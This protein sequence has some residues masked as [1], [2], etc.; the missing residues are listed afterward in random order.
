MIC[1]LVRVEVRQTIVPCSSR[2]LD[3]GIAGLRKIPYWEGCWG[4]WDYTALLWCCLLA[5]VARAGYR[6]IL[7]TWGRYGYLQA[8]GMNR[9][10]AGSVSFVGWLVACLDDSK[11]GDLLDSAQRHDSLAA[12]QTWGFLG[13]PR[14]R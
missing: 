2:V 1:T 11:H 13:D 7:L 12:E 4:V 10:V 3:V 9:F 14:P 8:G 6:K 5:S